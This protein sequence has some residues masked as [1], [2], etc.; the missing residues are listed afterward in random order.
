MKLCAMVGSIIRNI[1][2]SCLIIMVLTAADSWSQPDHEIE[3]S[4]FPSLMTSIRTNGSLDFCGEPVPLEEQ[5]IR[6][7]L[8]KELLLTLWDRP[9][10]I[11]WIKRSARYMPLIE[12]LL[13][14]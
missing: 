13:K 10:V 5:E 12:A 2:L 9:Q 14:E 3:P 7:R 6:E 1:V 8:E 11:L 4:Q